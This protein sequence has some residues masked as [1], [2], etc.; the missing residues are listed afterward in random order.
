MAYIELLTV[1]QATGERKE[2]YD[3]LERVRGKGKVSNLFKGYS[4]FPALGKANFNR[5]NVLLGKGKLSPKLKEGILTALAEIN[6]CEYCV[7]FHAT[8]MLNA[9]ADDGEV[10]AALAFDPDRL[11]L[12]EKEREL[13]NY[14]MKANGDP[15]SITE[16][17]IAK[18]RALGV[19]DWDLVET[20][21]TVNTGNSFN[22]FAGA[23]NIG[24]D[25]FLTY[26]TD[27]TSEHAEHGKPA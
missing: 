20:I 5:L 4:A 7:A 9:G 27:R 26:M 3:E 1:E 24:T 11:G 2:L 23:L 10:R 6:H 19:T 8:A 22:M 21:E 13:F 17:D 18:L 12:P 15:H 14:A 25:S 16:K